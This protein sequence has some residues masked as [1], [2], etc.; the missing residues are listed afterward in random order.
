MLL[1]GTNFELFHRAKS[2]GKRVFWASHEFRV[3][4]L[5]VAGATLLITTDMLLNATH[6][7]GD[8]LRYSSFQVVAIMTGTGFGTAG[9]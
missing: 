8:A 7:L 2:E 3:Y 5:L 1:A 4:T 9:L 6:G